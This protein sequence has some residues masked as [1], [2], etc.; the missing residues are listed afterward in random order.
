[1]ETLKTYIKSQPSRT[2]AEVA[3]DLGVSRPFLYGLLDGSRQ[4]SLDVA[5]RIDAATGGQVPITSWPRIRAIVEAT[6][7]AA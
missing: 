1:M 3:D 2:M 7:G 5:Q 4:P 6:R